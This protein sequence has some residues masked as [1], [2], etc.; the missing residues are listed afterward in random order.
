MTQPDYTPEH[1]GVY[2]RCKLCTAIS[3]AKMQAPT[4]E[5]LANGN[6]KISFQ[7]LAFVP[8]PVN[9]VMCQNPPKEAVYEQA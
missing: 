7:A 2:Y 5:K 8:L 4:I 3:N 6:T 9:C 1:T